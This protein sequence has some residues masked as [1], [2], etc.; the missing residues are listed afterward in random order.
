MNK[1]QLTEI[2]DD[3]IAGYD[4]SIKEGVSELV[5]YKTSK[6]IALDAFDKL[7][8]RRPFLFKII[9]AHNGELA[10][11]TDLFYLD[12]GEDTRAFVN[13]ASRYLTNLHG[14]R[15]P[16]KKSLNTHYQGLRGSRGTR[17]ADSGRRGYK[18]GGRLRAPRA[19]QR[20]K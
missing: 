20:R 16:R 5:S 11:N 4:Y 2:I 13:D 18:V 9:T 8:K 1:E 15:R 12:V 6:S 7:P 17:A 3:L 19:L 14:V 10:L